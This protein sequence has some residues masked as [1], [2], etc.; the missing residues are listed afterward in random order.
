M[1]RGSLY[2]LGLYHYMCMYFDSSSKAHVLRL[3]GP[4]TKATLAEP[5][6]GYERFVWVTAMQIICL[7]LCEKDKCATSH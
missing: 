7:E 2:S 3:L 6:S 1:Q 4:R 5:R